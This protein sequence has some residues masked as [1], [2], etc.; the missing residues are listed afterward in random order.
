MTVA[1]LLEA[2]K[3]LPLDA[4]VVKWSDADDGFGDSYSQYDSIGSVGVD[5][6]GRAVLY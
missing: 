5:A 2:L 4:E 3:G 6:E 1:E